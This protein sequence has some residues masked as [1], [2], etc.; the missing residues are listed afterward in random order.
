CNLPPQISLQVMLSGKDGTEKYALRRSGSL[1]DVVIS[2]KSQIFRAHRLVLACAS[3]RLAQQLAQSGTDIPAHCTLECFSPHTFQ[4]VLDFTYTQTLEVSVE[5]LY[6]L[7]RAA[8]LL[9]MESLE[10]Q[11]QKQLDTL[12]CRAVDRDKQGEMKDIKEEKEIDQKKNASPVREKKLQ[13][14]SKNNIVENLAP[15][16]STKYHKNLSPPRKKHRLLPS[17]SKVNNRDNVIAGPASNSTTFSPPW[18]FSSNMWSSVTTLR[19]IAESYSN[20][21]ASHPRQSPNQSTADYPFSLCTPPH[22]LPILAFQNPVRNSVMGYSDFYPRCTQN[23]Y[24][25]AA[26]MGGILKQGLLKRKPSQREFSKVTHSVE[27]R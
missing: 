13:E 1:C 20:L 18:T 19:Q 5:D 10:G 3:R 22:M 16:D 4:Q 6:L 17:S 24:T 2:V 21:I 27:Q 11:C 8:Q 14:A 23:L 7:L 12:D 25:G 9:E 26:G 15:T